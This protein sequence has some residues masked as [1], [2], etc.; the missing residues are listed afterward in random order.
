M[1]PWTVE[2]RTR[3][4]AHRNPVQAKAMETYMKD[5]FPFLGLKK[6]E[7]QELTYDLFTKEQ[8]P[9]RSDLEQIC[10]ELWDLEER[11][12][13]MVA[14]DLLR[15]NERKLVPA[16][17]EW[18]EDLI[19]DRSWWDTVDFLASHCVGAIYLRH[20]EVEPRIRTYIHSPEMWLNRVA[21]ICQIHHKGATNVALL[22][23]AMCSHLSS[24]EF[25]LR[26]GIGWAL[27]DYSKHNPDWV[28]AFIR[29]HREEMSAL[30]LREGGKYL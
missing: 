16:D 6:P 26:K 24:G 12:Y 23:E 25:F 4:E 3:L 14:L 1:H 21:I 10:R 18:L 11:E 30:S 20:R 2:I 17:M 9:S 5:L 27:R 19:L 13:A 29:D 8:L 22:S 7:R 15:K 28:R